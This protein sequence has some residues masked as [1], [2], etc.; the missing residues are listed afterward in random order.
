MRSGK[1]WTCFIPTTIRSQSQRSI[2]LDLPADI[3]VTITQP[4]PERFESISWKHRSPSTPINRLSPGSWYPACNQVAPTM[5]QDTTIRLLCD[6]SGIRLWSNSSSDPW[7]LACRL[8]HSNSFLEERGCRWNLPSGNGSPV[9]WCQIPE[10]TTGREPVLC[11][12]KK[13]QRWSESKKIHCS[14]ER[15]CK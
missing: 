7:R 6:G 9:R 2:H 11:S 4:E 15:N 8:N 14:D 5:S 10:K 12:E 1:L 3:Q 13:V